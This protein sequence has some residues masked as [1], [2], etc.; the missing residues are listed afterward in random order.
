MAARTILIT[1]DDQKAAE[2]FVLELYNDGLM[3]RDRQILVPAGTKLD[4]MIARP[5]LGCH[6]TGGTGKMGKHSDFGWRQVPKFGWWVHA[7]C[8]RPS[9][10]VVRDWI[11][12]MLNGA[13]NLLPVLI[14]DREWVQPNKVIDYDGRSLRA[15]S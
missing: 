14:P 10:T 12:N 4:A 6:C 2:Q 11:R 3:D 13:H 5:S 15:K 7:R 9:A 1:I 8:K